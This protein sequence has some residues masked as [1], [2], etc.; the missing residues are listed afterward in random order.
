MAGLAKAAKKVTKKVTSKAKPKK[1]AKRVKKADRPAW[2]KDMSEK[3][4]KQS[5]GSP[6]RGKDGV[7]RHKKGGKVSKARGAGK[8]QRG[9]GKLGRKK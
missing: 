7:V 1:A 4:Y 8:A 3:E 2:A 6:T 9:L 5:L